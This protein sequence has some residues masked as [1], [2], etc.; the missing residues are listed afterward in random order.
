MSELVGHADEVGW[1]ALKA[2]LMLVLVVAALRI[3]QRRTLAQFNSF[4]FAVAVALGAIVGRTIT[5]S[6][7]SFLTG[8]VALI[9]LLVAH[10]LITSVRRRFRLHAVFDQPP[11]VLIV[12]GQLQHRGMARAGLTDADVFALLRQR[13][14]GGLG[15]VDYL[16][17]EA[18]GGVSLQRAGTPLGTLMRDALIAAGHDPGSGSVSD[19]G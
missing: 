14:V 5:S 19:C 18:R 15:D 6:T 8:A 4:D 7:T 1:L 16:L 10:G 12:H 3:G 13:E 17:Y 2:A 11:N 9:T